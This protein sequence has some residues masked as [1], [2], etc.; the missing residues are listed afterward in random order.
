MEG[1]DGRQAWLRGAQAGQ[2]SEALD[3]NAPD[4]IDMAINIALL[5][6]A[7]SDQLD[8]VGPPA[9]TRRQQL[10][11][12]LFAPLGKS[13]VTKGRSGGAGVDRRALRDTEGLESQ[14]PLAVA[15]SILHHGQF[16][17]PVTSACRV[18][19]LPCAK[20]TSR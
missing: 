14:L 9:G 17:L 20:T 19:F 16:A 4:T 11:Q 2:S 8:E 13:P 6:E 15:A 10:G 1:A 12:A 18:A 7:L 5:D 3:S